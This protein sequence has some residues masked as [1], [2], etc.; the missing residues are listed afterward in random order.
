MGHVSANKLLLWVFCLFVVTMLRIALCYNYHHAPDKINVEDWA[1]WFYLGTLTLSALLGAAGSFLLPSPADSSYLHGIT[2]LDGHITLHPFIAIFIAVLVAA[3]VTN[4]AVD[5]KA[6]FYLA[7]P[8][9]FLIMVSFLSEGAAHGYLLAMLTLIAFLIITMYAIRLNKILLNTI[10]LQLRLATRKDATEYS[11]GLLERNISEKNLK[12]K[13]TNKQLR[14][15]ISNRKDIES[16][17]RSNEQKFRH[18]VDGIPGAVFRCDCGNEWVMEFV[19]NNIE[20]ITGYPAQ[21]FEGSDIQLYMDLIHQD[22]IKKVESALLESVNHRQPFDVEYRISDKKRRLRWFH[23]KGEIRYSEEDRLQG[24]DG[25]L[26]DITESHDLTEKLTYLAT[27]D[28][29]TD[30]A[31]RYEFERELLALLEEIENIKTEHTLCYLDLDQFKVINDTYGHSVGDDLLAGF[32]QLLKNQVGEQDTVARLGGDEFAILVRNCT[33]VHAV[34]LAKKVRKA[35]ED[36][37]FVY[38]DNKLSVGVSIGVVNINSTNLDASEI[39]KQA[40]AAC[41]TAKENGRNSIYVYNHDD[42]KL[43][44]LQANMYWATRLKYSL[45]ENLLQLHFQPIVPIKNTQSKDA[46]YEVLIRMLPGPDEIDSGLILP[47][48]FLPAAEQFGLSGRLDYWVIEN[49][50][51]HMAHLNSQDSRHA[52]FSVNLSGQS[53]ENKEF[54]EHIFTLFKK[55]TFLHNRICFEI[56]ESAAITNLDSATEFIKTFKNFGCRFALDDFGKGLSSFGYLKNLSVDYLKIDGMFIKEIVDDMTNFSIVKAI[57]E[58]AHATGKTTIAEYVENAEILEKLKEIGVD[59]AQ[60]YHIGKPIA[61]G[62]L[63][64]EQHCYHQK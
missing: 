55:H 8:A 23:G 60:G 11:H 5:L 52:K 50:Y 26:F 2:P 34:K 10:I 28:S 33:I 4:Y 46:Y 57:N 35:I 45:E 43:M 12:L 25:V 63:D 21:Y 47:N 32:G 17:L 31:N 9:T 6:Y 1:M 19:S 30:L 64:A 16:H 42:S 38:G 56:T 24:I 40:D 62:D 7:L 61:L 41:Y 58:V 37:R 36:Y 22:D 15:E 54:L 13:E 53:L 51:K 20:N 39:M 49:L 18:L 14:N 3:A 48:K 44:T 59:Y 29:L 27:H